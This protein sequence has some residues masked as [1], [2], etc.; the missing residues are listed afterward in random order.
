MSARETDAREGGRGV[1]RSAQLERLNRTEGVA[2]DD[3]APEN[4]NF[5]HFESKHLRAD[6]YRTLVSQGVRPGAKAPDFELPRV[7][8]GSQRLS[9][10]F[11][12][13]ILLHFGSFT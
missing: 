7:G 9:F 11:G 3:L 10:L 4:Y 13:P 1:E 12:K 2:G 8:G 6:G 5:E